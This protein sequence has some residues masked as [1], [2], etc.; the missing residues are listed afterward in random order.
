MGSMVS[1]LAII[2]A[3]EV[4]SLK[5]ILK[6]SNLLGK[7]ILQCL[8]MWKIKDSNPTHL[9]MLKERIIS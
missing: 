4:D 2:I 5:S 1:Q 3:L 7:D 9:D 8:T 6:F